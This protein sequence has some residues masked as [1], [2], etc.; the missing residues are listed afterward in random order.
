MVAKKKKKKVKMK[1]PWAR[2][3]L[4]GVVCGEIWKSCN[5]MSFLL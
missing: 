1:S 4:G 2:E 5:K 3:F